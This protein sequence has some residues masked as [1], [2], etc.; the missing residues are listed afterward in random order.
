MPPFHKIGSLYDD[1]I[2]IAVV[3]FANNFAMSKLFA[4][5]QC[6]DL[7]SNAVS[8][9]PLALGSLSSDINYYVVFLQEFIAY[10]VTNMGSSFFSCYTSAASLSRSLIQEAVGGKTQVRSCSPVHAC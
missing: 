5:K 1:A 2:G 9:R 6:Y 7:D 4:R 3:A 10:G 8:S